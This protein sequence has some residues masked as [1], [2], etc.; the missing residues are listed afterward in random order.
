MLFW[1]AI[2]GGIYL[3]LLI[4][5]TIDAR[6]T[7]RSSNDYVFAGSNLG[8]I[9]GSLTF[10][11]T[12]FSTFTLMGMPDFFRTH[13]IG[14][15]IFLGVA[16]AAIAFVIIWFGSHL[17]NRAESTDFQGMAG[18]L[19]NCYSSRW[20]GYLYL[21]GIFVFLIP[22]VAIQI[23]GIS[24]FLNAA[25]PT[26]LTVEGWAV[27][28]VFVMLVYSELGGLKAIIYSDSFQGL[29]LLVVTWI[30]AY[31]CISRIGGV[32]SLFDQ[33]E[34]VNSAL[35]SIPGPN[36]L[37]T[38]QFLLT[39]FLVILFLPATQ[40]QLAT[41]IIIMR[42][43]RIMQ[44]MGVSLGI[45]AML[46]ILP[47]IAVGMYGAVYYSD[48]NTSE[49]LAQVLLFDQ[50]P[51]IGATVVVGL[52]AA[53][54]STADSQIFALGTELRSMLS[55]EEHAVMV[56]T[57]L[58][59]VGFA[60]AALVF[61]ILSSDELVLLARVSFAGTALL[62][63]LIL[64]GVLS[65]WQLGK[66][67]IMVT[68]LALAV[69]MLS[70]TGLIPDSLGLIRMDLMLLLNLGAFTA[71]AVCYRAYLASKADEGAVD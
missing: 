52:I 68:A 17:R 69:F 62:G 56:R 41:R 61:A 5:V 45:F 18:F 48:A 33:V 70:L 1:L 40:P 25:F 51:V 3:L 22:Y 23:R 34:Q 20:A 2:V 55:G 30:I 31:T 35:L 6:R 42:G 71:L 54:M 59:I 21:F 58:A 47:T 36:G 37:F 50:M 63:P 27:A 38:T 60:L 66:E 8:I 11:A 10:G 32:S 49:F 67:V 7:T 43:T 44:I 9:L 26:G 64:A 12:L 65:P 19:N 13:G 28:I 15:W 46:V 29:V 24:I 4:F 39:S 16:D 57:K 53:A 14:A